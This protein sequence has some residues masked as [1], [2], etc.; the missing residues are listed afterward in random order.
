MNF[1]M[2]FGA[3]VLA[4][5]V[6]IGALSINGKTDAPAAADGHGHG[7]DDHGHGHH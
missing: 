2:A 5:L 7:H 3:L 4:S 6:V 1:W